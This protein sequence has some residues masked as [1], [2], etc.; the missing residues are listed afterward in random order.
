[1]QNKVRLS[2]VQ[3]LW[4]VK[5]LG[6]SWKTEAYSSSGYKCAEIL[7]PTG[8]IELNKDECETLQQ[9]SQLGFKSIPPGTE[10]DTKLG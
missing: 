9:S 3:R 4:A 8:L 6:C 7:I 5:S 2:Q 10:G 1:M